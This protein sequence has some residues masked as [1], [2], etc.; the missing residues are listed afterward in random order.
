M[1][2]ATDIIE[3]AVG[4]VEG[5]GHR[6]HLRLAMTFS[7]A[8]ATMFAARILRVHVANVSTRFKTVTARSLS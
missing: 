3:V 4:A 5:N 1:A 8:I 2:Q 6:R 7:L